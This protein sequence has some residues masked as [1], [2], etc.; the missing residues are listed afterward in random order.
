MNQPS[1]IWTGSYAEFMAVPA[2]DVALMPPNLSFEEAAGVPLTALTAWQVRCACHVMS[3]LH[4]PSLDITV[5]TKS[6]TISISAF[7]LNKFYI[8]QNS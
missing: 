7:A 8:F 6:A 2:D 3:P 4:V 5:F 1:C